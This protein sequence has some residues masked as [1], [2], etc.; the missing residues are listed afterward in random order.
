[1]P[2][3]RLDGGGQVVVGKHPLENQR[4]LH[5]GR[6]PDRLREEPDHVLEVGRRAQAA[7]PPRR[8]VRAAPPRRPGLPLLREAR[9]HGG[10]HEI[11]PRDDH[12][13]DV[14]VERIAE[15][16]REE[17]G[18]G[19]SRLVVVVDDLGIPRPVHLPVHVLGFRLEGR[20]EV[21]VVVVPHVLLVEDGD[22]ARG[23]LRL[24]LDP[25][26]PVRDEVHPVGVRVDE[27]DDD[28]VEDPHRLIVGPAHELPQRLHELLR[29]QHF[30]GVEAAV[31][32]HDGLAAL[33]EFSRLRLGHAPG[34]REAG[35]DLPVFVEVRVVLGRGDDRHELVSALGGRP[36]RLQRHAR[37]FGGQR[38]P[39]AGE[40]AVVRQFV[41]GADLVA[42]EGLRGRQFLREAGPRGEDAEDDRGGGQNAAGRSPG[43]AV[44][45]EERHVRTLLAQIVCR[46]SAPIMA[47]ACPGSQSTPARKR[48]RPPAS[49]IFRAHGGRHRLEPGQVPAMAVRGKTPLGQC[50]GGIGTCT[51]SPRSGRTPAACSAA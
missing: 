29:A 14:V 11:D 19:G 21:P 50:I 23:A 2:R 18:P 3:L 30:R 20:V 31:D 25:R 48:R 44:G 34:E 42:E 24:L 45:G 51:G 46:V 10:P 27:E 6:V 15:R 49:P 28:V 41:V 37:G 36:D 1:M 8:V 9:V 38:L 39:V 33:R 43:S 4:D 13:V 40:V 26:V 32:P 5:R 22:P 17:H 47:T 16:G 35:G 12:R 7:V